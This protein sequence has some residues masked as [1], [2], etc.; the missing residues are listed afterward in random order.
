MIQI[1]LCLKAADSDF[2][3]FDT[4]DPQAFGRIYDVF[5]PKIFGYA[6]RRMGDY[7]MARDVAA[8]TFFKSFS[9]RKDSR[10]EADIPF[11]HGCIKLRPMRS[12]SFSETKNTAR[13]AW[14][15]FGRNAF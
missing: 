14:P 9:E 1:A 6:F 7:D 11:R 5:Y 8:E 2:K 13:F 3:E 15:T 4:N 10:F 12:T